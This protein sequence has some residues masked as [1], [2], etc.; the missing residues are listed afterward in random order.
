MFF[1]PLLFWAIPTAAQVREINWKQIQ[2]PIIGDVELGNATGTVKSPTGEFSHLLN[3][4]NVTDFADQTLSATTGSTVYS[5]TEGKIYVYDGSAW[6]EISGATSES[7]S[8]SSGAVAGETIVA[9]TDLTIAGAGYYRYLFPNYA[10]PGSPFYS[11]AFKGGT[12]IVRIGPDAEF[13]PYVLLLPGATVGSHRG[14]RV[15]LASGETFS[16][17]WEL[18]ILGVLED[19]DGIPW[20]NLSSDRAGGVQFYSDPLSTR[21]SGRFLRR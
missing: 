19:A 14:F 1:V 21:V 5:A 10:D 15:N 4:P 20:S 17:A 7:G 13:T 2:K 11:K 18:R 12:P 16:A 3:L 6:A 8:G 9:V